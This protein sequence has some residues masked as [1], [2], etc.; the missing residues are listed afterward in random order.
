VRL[1]DPEVV[2]AEYASETGLEGRRAAY[3]FREGPDAVSMALE[4]VTESRPRDVLE[5]GCG[6]GELSQRVEREIG[7]AVIAIDISP[8][9]VELARARGVDAHVGDVQDLPFG[10]AEFDCAIAAWV[11]YHVP[12]VTVGISELARVLRPGGRL[13]AVTNGLDHLAELR[14]LIGLPPVRAETPFSRENG[15][16]ALRRHFASVDV[17]D[18]RGSIV[19]P[20]RAA[21]EAYVAAS[22]SLWS[23]EAGALPQFGLPFVVRTRPVIFVAKK[24]G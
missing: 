10:D 11:L 3:R 18:A 21:V 19:F 12:D 15:E 7:A 24:A 22:S 17:R 14:E 13:V 16:S 23:V 9:M 8:R 1:N 4:A 20:D 5:V 6:P 2:A